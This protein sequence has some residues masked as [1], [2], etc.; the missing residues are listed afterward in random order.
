MDLKWSIGT[1]YGMEKVREVREGGDE[2]DGVTG[3]TGDG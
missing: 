1:V 2:S 3:A